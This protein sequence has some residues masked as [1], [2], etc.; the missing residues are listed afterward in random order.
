METKVTLSMLRS[1]NR[2]DVLLLE[3]G[4]KLMQQARS[5]AASEGAGLYA[6]RRV[7]NVD[8]VFVVLRK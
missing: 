8:N 7:R 3:G 6:V 1:L 2:G 5:L 4:D